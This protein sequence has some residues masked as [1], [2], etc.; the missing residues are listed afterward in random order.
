MSNIELT[1]VDGDALTIY[2][3]DESTWITCTSGT[4]EV[5]VGPFPTQVVRS[6]V[7]R[8]FEVEGGTLSAL[9]RRTPGGTMR[10]TEE[11]RE[12]AWEAF[13]LESGVQGGEEE[14]AAREALDRA[15]EAALA[16]PARPPAAEALAD[17]LRRA[18]I[19]IA[20][21]DRLADHL[22]AHGYRK[23]TSL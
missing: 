4:E 14:A 18:A 10:L 1:D 2:I 11:M 7:D 3:R 8:G 19:T 13:S 5:T 9:V 6:V 21:V 16:S 23:G 15:L 12:R 17:E 22:V 20:D